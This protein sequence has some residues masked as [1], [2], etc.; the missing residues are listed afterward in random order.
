VRGLK[1]AASLAP[2]T[3]AASAEE[4]LK[5]KA[6]PPAVLSASSSSP[7]DTER[8]VMAEASR[9]RSGRG[10]ALAEPAGPPPVLPLSLLPA[11]AEEEE[12]EAAEAS[13]LLLLLGSDCAAPQLSVRA[14]LKKRLES[15]LFS[16]TLSRPPV[17]PARKPLAM[18]AREAMPQLGPEPGTSSCPLKSRAVLP[19]L[20]PPELASK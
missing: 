1:R 4:S 7:G 13:L 3:G 10:P 18:G 8:Q 5:R 12:E 14:T 16:K 15:S 19:P 20:L 9:E 11:S 17:Q 2:L 6:E